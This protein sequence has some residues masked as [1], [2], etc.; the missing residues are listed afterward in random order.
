MA[1]SRVRR[2]EEEKDT[3][4]VRVLT[5][6]RYNDKISTEFESIETFHKQ[7]LHRCQGDQTAEQHNREPTLA[8][9][10]LHHIQRVPQGIFLETFECDGGKGQ[11]AQ[12]A[13]DL[14]EAVAVHNLQQEGGI[15]DSD[16]R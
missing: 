8:Q 9:L 6:R 5:P 12:A 16:K 13:R 1:A 15:K 10:C 7:Q 3:A 4:H 14:R 11:Q 2:S